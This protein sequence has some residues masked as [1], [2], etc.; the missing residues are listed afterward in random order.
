MKEEQELLVKKYRS[1]SKKL[2]WTDDE[3]SDFY[4]SFADWLE[5]MTD[6]PEVNDDYTLEDAGSDLY[7]EYKEMNNTAWMFDCDDQDEY[8]ES[9]GDLITD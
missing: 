2:Q 8:E 6:F 7:E 4:D 3:K 1:L 9:Y 5:E